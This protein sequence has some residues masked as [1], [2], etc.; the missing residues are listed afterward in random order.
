MLF[1]PPQN[2]CFRLEV[3]IRTGK[4]QDKTIT[5]L[6][7]GFRTRQVWVQIVIQ[8]QMFR[9]LNRP[10]RKYIFF[11]WKYDYSVPL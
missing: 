4:S 2:I 10:Y 9:A 7:N 11:N 5:S 8:M 6:E 3:C 1:F